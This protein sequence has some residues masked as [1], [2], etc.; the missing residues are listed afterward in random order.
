MND[1]ITDVANEATV[2]IPAVLTVPVGVT[3]VDRE[4]T[5]EEYRRLQAEKNT[6]DKEAV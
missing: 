6:E 2:S 4:L 1:Q 3:A 5:D